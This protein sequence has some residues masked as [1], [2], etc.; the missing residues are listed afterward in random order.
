MKIVAP[1][2]SGP[3]P[4]KG[5]GKK[6][7]RIQSS[8]SLDGRRW[9]WGW[10]PRFDMPWHVATLI[11][12]NKSN[13]YILNSFVLSWFITPVYFHDLFSCHVTSF[14]DNEWICRSISPFR[15]GVWGVC[16][17]LRHWEERFVRRENLIHP[18]RHCE[19]RSDVAI[20]SPCSVIAR[21]AATWQSHLVIFII[22]KRWDPHALKKRGL[23]MTD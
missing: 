20:S 3:S 23:R 21:S 1:P 4:T 12:R 14:D 6:N 5:R 11:G 16:I 9:G 7:K 17:L 13:P 10:K 2:H 15:K 22:M 19:E 18:L 8:F